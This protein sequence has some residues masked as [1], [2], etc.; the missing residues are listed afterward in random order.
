M[1]ALKK[2]MF[3]QTRAA[4]DGRRVLEIVGTTPALD[5]DGESITAEGW[6]LDNYLKNPV[7]M[8]G[9]NYVDRPVARTVAL[10]KSPEGLV[11]RIQFP[12]EEQ[13]GDWFGFSDSVYRMMKSGF[14]NASSVGF[15]PLE[16]ADGDG[17]GKSAP[18]RTFTKQ[19]LL[20]LSIVPVPSNPEAL[21]LG[22]QSGAIKSCDRRAIETMLRKETEGIDGLANLG[23]AERIEAVLADYAE[24]KEKPIAI[25][26][27]PEPD[28]GAEDEPE[29]ED[30]D[31][32]DEKI[33]LRDL[34]DEVAI[35]TDTV[36]TLASQ[37][38]R[39][40]KAYKALRASLGIEKAA[41]A[42]APEDDLDTWVVQE[43]D[44]IAKRREGQK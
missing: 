16:W 24:A 9:H 17:D 40:V 39:L 43:L 14:I 35:L 6:Q 27:P 11:F 42:P 22:L 12:T 1:D 33:T 8:F 34:Y 18:R 31:E 26:E 13:A 23:W 44:A 29:D 36:Q 7:V 38:S 4:D 2:T 37:F 10:A 28:E 3:I 25:E 41:A 21:R 15:M 19:D 32:E 5:R 30:E 20:E